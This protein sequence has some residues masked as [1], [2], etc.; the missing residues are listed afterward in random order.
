MSKRH[1]HDDQ[2]DVDEETYEE[3]GSRFSRLGP[4]HVEKPLKK[5]HQEREDSVKREIVRKPKRDR[6]EE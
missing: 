1:Y 6:F 3:L 5:L 2:D 4:S